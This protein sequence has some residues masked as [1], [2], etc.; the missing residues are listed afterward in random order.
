MY[1]RVDKADSL[2]WLR[3]RA[4]NNDTLGAAA[5]GGPGCGVPR[6]VLAADMFPYVTSL[7]PWISAMSSV[8]APGG[9]AAFTTEALMRKE[10]CRSRALA[11]RL[12]RSD[13]DF[14][15][16]SYLLRSTYSPRYAHSA[17]HVA[18]AARAAGMEVVAHNVSTMRMEWALPVRSHV[19]LLRKATS[20]P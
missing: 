3:G 12:P 1:Q 6:L 18:L 9:Y 16:P 10:E 11:L 13:A 2:Q 19:V 4:F 14:G 17:A 15:W 8:L 7:R 20:E 5:D